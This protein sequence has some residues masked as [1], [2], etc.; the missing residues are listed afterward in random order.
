MPVWTQLANLYSGDL[1][2]S[3]GPELCKEVTSSDWTER[4]SF[5]KTM[6]IDWTKM[7][8]QKV[9]VQGG[10][11]A[12]K[13]PIH[14][15]S[16]GWFISSLSRS[17]TPKI[18]NPAQKPARHPTALGCM[19]CAK[20]LL[21]VRVG[22]RCVGHKP[23]QSLSCQSLVWGPVLSAPSDTSSHVESRILNV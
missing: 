4:L 15:S 13:P 1:W 20:A 9:S 18:T 6:K 17:S 23:R 19:G 5:Q 7:A 8:T 11:Y 12:E 21:G 3:L 14:W 2:H 22:S 16:R 10:S